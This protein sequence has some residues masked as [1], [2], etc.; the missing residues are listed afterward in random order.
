MTIDPRHV[1]FTLKPDFPAEIQYHSDTIDQ[2]VTVNP[3]ESDSHLG[4]ALLESNSIYAA[5]PSV[6]GK[7]PRLALRESTTAKAPK[8][9]SN[10]HQ[11]PSKRPYRS[12]IED[13]TPMEGQ[14]T[15]SEEDAMLKNKASS[16]HDS[17]VSSARGGTHYARSSLSLDPSSTTNTRLSED[18]CANM[19]LQ[20]RIYNADNERKVKEILDKRLPLIFHT[21]NALICSMS[22]EDNLRSALD[23]YHRDVRIINN[24]RF[25]GAVA[26]YNL[27]YF[28]ANEP[29]GHI[30]GDSQ[31]SAHKMNADFRSDL[32]TYIERDHCISTNDVYLENIN[33]EEED[34]H[35]TVQVIRD[36]HVKEH[37]PSPI[38]LH[39]ECRELTKLLKGGNDILNAIEKYNSE[40]AEILIKIE[41]CRTNIDCN[42]CYQNKCDKKSLDRKSSDIMNEKKRHDIGN[43]TLTQ[44]ELNLE[45][46]DMRQ[47]SRVRSGVL[48]LQASCVG[49]YQMLLSVFG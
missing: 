3:V 27:K 49:L 6:G 9:Y 10:K 40:R 23:E 46:L 4:N 15:L 44:M 2:P 25:T 22:M 7:A 14:S 12:H 32:E 41:G 24:Q 31:N 28:T 30:H 34:T 29:E 39:Q 16:T 37:T 20:I 38:E 47:L 5:C 18:A 21:C 1:S 33:S 43:S 8:A 36:T 26:P 48:E 13:V 42:G 17:V 19:E 45:M 11:E 35:E